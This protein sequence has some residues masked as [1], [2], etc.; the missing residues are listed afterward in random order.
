MDVRVVSCVVVSVFVWGKTMAPTATPIMS[1]TPLIVE[2][3]RLRSEVKV[4]CDRERE[5]LCIQLS[6]M[7]PVRLQN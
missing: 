3:L 2:E 1:A 4:P 6:V 7:Q 5:T